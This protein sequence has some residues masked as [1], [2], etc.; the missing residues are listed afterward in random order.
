MRSPPV[1]F[2][3]FSSGNPKVGIFQIDLEISQKT[4]PMLAEMVRPAIARPMGYS[5]PTDSIQR[6]VYARQKFILNPEMPD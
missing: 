4:H 5:S 3:W 1:L 6:Q 2:S